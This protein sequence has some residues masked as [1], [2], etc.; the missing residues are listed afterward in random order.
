M[1]YYY[2]LWERRSW[3]GYLLDGNLGGWLQLGVGGH[4][5]QHAGRQWKKQIYTADKANMTTW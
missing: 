1:V 3:R 4:A 2:V 5:G